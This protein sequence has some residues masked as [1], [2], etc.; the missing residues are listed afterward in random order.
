MPIDFHSPDRAGFMWELILSDD[1]ATIARLETDLGLTQ[2]QA[3]DEFI[4]TSCWGDDLPHL[5]GKRGTPERR[6]E[7]LRRIFR[8]DKN[9]WG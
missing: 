8:A 9:H 5:T 7:A 2:A 6:L 1:A 4:E 3:V